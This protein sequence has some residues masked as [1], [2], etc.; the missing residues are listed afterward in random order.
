MQNMQFKKVGHYMM[1]AVKKCT[2]IVHA[3]HNINKKKANNEYKIEI[4]KR[5]LWNGSMKYKGNRRENNKYPHRSFV[6]EEERR[7]VQVKIL[8]PKD[9]LI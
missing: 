2:E 3:V 7:L 9:N 4:S 6:L 8:R 5:Y 1:G